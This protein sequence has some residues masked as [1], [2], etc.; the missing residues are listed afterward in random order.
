MLLHCQK[1]RQVAGEKYDGLYDLF[2][3]ET[4]YQINPPGEDW[5]SVYIATD[6]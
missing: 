2:D 1:A 5:D 3:E 4:E 6:K